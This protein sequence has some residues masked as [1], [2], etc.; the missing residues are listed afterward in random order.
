MFGL[1][2]ALAEA[3]Q[4]EMRRAAQRNI[5]LSS[6]KESHREP[7]EVPEAMITIRL[8]SQADDAA[9]ERLAGLDSTVAPA[10]PVLIAEVNGRMRAALSLRDGRSVADPFVATSGIVQLLASRARQLGGQHESTWRRA[11]RRRSDVLS[12]NVPWAAD[13]VAERRP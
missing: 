6:A 7:E 10:A 3:Q 9:L 5:I 12:G 8:G 13:V 11:L 2:E 4:K 1:H